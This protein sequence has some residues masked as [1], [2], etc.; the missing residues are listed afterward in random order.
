[1]I[2]DAALPPG[3]QPSAATSVER[4]G[5]F[6]TSARWAPDDLARL[7][8]HLQGQGAEALAGISDTELLEAWS[9][10]VEVFRDP[11]SVVRQA[12][13]RP[14]SRFCRLSP[15]GLSAGLEAVLGGVVG[16][17]AEELVREAAPSI[18]DPVLV[19][20]AANL[21]ALA[22]QPLLPALA[23][24]RPVL[25]KSPSSEPLFAPAFVAAL[26]VRLPALAPAL[27]AITWPGGDAALEAPLLAAAGRVVAYGEQESLDDLEQRAP[28]KVVAYGPKT[29]LAVVGAAVEPQ[30]VAAG[31]A[32]DVALFDQRGCLSIQAVYTL[33]DPTALA[34]ALAA[35]L[36]AVAEEWPSGPLDPVSVAAV[37]QIRSEAQMR[38][39]I[40]P[41]LAIDVGTVVVEPQL[42]FRPSPGVRTV[43]VH[44]L[45]RTDRLPE[46]LAPWAGQLQG[47]ALAG[48]DA[49][50]LQKNLEAL[51]I[52]RCA[53]PGQLQTPDALWHN[54][55]VH[56]LITLAD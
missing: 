40:K 17:P 43:R 45:D 47:A 49:W 16:R 52:S 42:D 37:Q 11:G 39:L 26:A 34:E 35:E 2:H 1:M 6:Y 27:A 38:G 53:E 48:D 46:I 36:V 4:E 9:A 54:G 28:G 20:L 12:L 14:L 24:R 41:E 31:L 5:V 30:S 7:G 10:T 3:L 15:E 32:R 21:P 25:L 51:G 23:L 29:S 22:V 8:E 50:A 13:D 18:R 55:G 33:G 19:I 56:P 44:P